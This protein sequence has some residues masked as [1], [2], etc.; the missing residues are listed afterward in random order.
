MIK[1]FVFC[2][3]RSQKCNFITNTFLIRLII[4]AFVKQQKKKRA[5]ADTQMFGILEDER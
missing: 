4:S 3:F 5:S 2:R 1:T